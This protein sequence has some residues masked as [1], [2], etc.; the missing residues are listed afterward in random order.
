MRHRVGQLAVGLLMSLLA[1][2]ACT[3]RPPDL[4]LAQSLA[5][6]ATEILAGVELL[7]SAVIEAE[8]GRLLSEDAAATV[9]MGIRRVL[10]LAGQVPSALR[11]VAA[12]DA[13]SHSRAVDDARA[14]VA[15]LSQVLAGIVLP[16]ELDARVLAVLQKVNALLL[17]L[18]S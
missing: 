10:I 2:T 8:R 5:V 3:K 13:F 17:V 11:T 7:Q 16:A 14:L 12:A 18:D 6:R 4:P 15:T 1:L 9:L